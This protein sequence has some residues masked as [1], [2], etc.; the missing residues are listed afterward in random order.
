MMRIV[1]SCCQLAMRCVLFID[2]M[3]CEDTVVTSINNF[4]RCQQTKSGM[5]I[6]VK[7]PPSHSQTDS[8]IKQKY[9]QKASN[10]HK[11]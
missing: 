10:K 5:L 7:A 11:C 2:I 9:K 6:S 4:V 1:F 8:S 3:F